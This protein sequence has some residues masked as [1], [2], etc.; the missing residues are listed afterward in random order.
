MSNAG[1]STD[2][3]GG[4]SAAPAPADPASTKAS[5]SAGG[6]AP[7]DPAPKLTKLPIAPLASVH[8]TGDSTTTLVHSLTQQTKSMPGLWELETDEAG[9]CGVLVEIDGEGCRDLEEVLNLVVATREGD[10]TL[11]LVDVLRGAKSARPLDNIRTPHKMAKC[12]MHA[13]SSAATFPLHCDVMK[14]P[15]SCRCSCYWRMHDIY[16]CL[17]LTSYRC[18]SKWM[19]TWLP[20]WQTNLF[21]QELGGYHIIWGTYMRE[22]LQVRGQLPWHL[23]C[24]TST[25][26][27]TPALLMLLCRWTVLSAQS[28]GLT[29]ASCRTASNELLGSILIISRKSAWKRSASRL[30]R[31]LPGCLRGH[32]RV[33]S[34]K[35]RI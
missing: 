23:R 19:G 6:P 31:C 33:A 2:H 10:P 28:G 27:S 11:Q 18:N 4:A 24:L 13:A 29:Q 34:L 32:S 26:V 22:G 16:K 25:G 1:S 30:R 15:R 12:T 8:H 21:A 7:A 17:R 20:N 14:Q 35:R 3:V 9:L 5:S